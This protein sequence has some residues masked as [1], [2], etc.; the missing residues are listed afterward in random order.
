MSY[1]DAVKTKGFLISTDPAKLYDEHTE[2]YAMSLAQIW[3][4]L[5]VMAFVVLFFIRQCTRTGK[6]IYRRCTQKYEANGKDIDIFLVG[7]V[8]DTKIM[9]QL[10][11]DLT[12]CD[13]NVMKTTG[14]EIF[15]PDARKS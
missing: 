14:N 7:S 15:L 10:A 8:K 4:S 12:K 5:F 9:N 1:R 2:S 6:L 3:L 13:Y 11:S